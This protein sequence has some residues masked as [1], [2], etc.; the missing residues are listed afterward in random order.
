MNTDG[1]WLFTHLFNKT[2]KNKDEDE[3]VDGTEEGTEFIQIIK[4]APSYNVL[5]FERIVSSSW[6]KKINPVITKVILDIVTE[7]I[8]KI[9]KKKFHHQSIQEDFDFVMDISTLIPNPYSHSPLLGKDI[10]KITNLKYKIN[11]LIDDA[12]MENKI[13]NSMFDNEF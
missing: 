10:A 5:E 2:V 11:K 13:E 8:E 7:K 3:G 6:N 9:E 4:S 12:E 1:Y